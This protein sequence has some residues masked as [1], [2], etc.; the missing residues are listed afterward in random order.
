[1]LKQLGGRWSLLWVLSQAQRNEGL[2]VFGPASVDIWRVFLHDVED[3]AALRFTDVWWVAVRHLHRENT[4]RPNVHF[5]SVLPLSANQ[6][7]SHPAHS[8]DLA[9]APGFL[10][11]ELHS[12][13][14]VCKLHLSLGVEQ[15]VVRL[16]V[17]VNN[18]SIVQEL[19]TL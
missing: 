4:K 10:L 2:E 11:G 5:G 19:E 7:W 9:L 14:E 12:V 18:V 13:A 15:Q 6:L 8:A 17:S 1:M 3:N 16:D